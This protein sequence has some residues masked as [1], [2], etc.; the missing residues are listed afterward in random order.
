MLFIYYSKN[1]ILWNV[2]RYKMRNSPEP[3]KVKINLLSPDRTKKTKK[4]ESPPKK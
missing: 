4:S 2:N 3:K 1:I